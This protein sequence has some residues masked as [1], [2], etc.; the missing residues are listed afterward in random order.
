MSDGERQSAP[1]PWTASVSPEELRRTLDAAFGDLPVAPGRSALSFLAEALV[2]LR[3]WMEHQIANGVPETAPG[4]L[5][6]SDQLRPDGEGLQ[7]ERLSFF[8]HDHNHP[9]CGKIT[10]CSSSLADAYQGPCAA[11]TIAELVRTLEASGLAD[12]PTVLVLLA[13]RK[14]LVCPHGIRVPD[15]AYIVEVPVNSVDEVSEASVQELLERFYVTCIRIPRRYGTLWKEPTRYVPI[16]QAERR[17]QHQLVPITRMRF[18][19]G[20]RVE[21]EA[22]TDEGRVDISVEPVPG[23]NARGSCILELKVLRSR[24]PSSTGRSRSCPPNENDEAVVKGIDQA[25]S[26]R[27]TRNAGLAFLVC[28]DFREDGDEQY[29]DR[30]RSLGEPRAVRMLWFPVYPD[31][32][33]ARQKRPGSSYEE[34][35]E[36]GLIGD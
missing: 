35:I 10:L 20:F 31:V 27:D 11:E 17:I 14:L 24:Y 12:R 6:L 9:V 23:A 1:H 36:F 5:L 2:F 19:N 34:A 7:F 26:Y 3:G 15:D 18:F 13:Q 33:T 4:A 30:F 8:R 28:Y 22:D 29:L 21:M 25:A 32:E 16:P